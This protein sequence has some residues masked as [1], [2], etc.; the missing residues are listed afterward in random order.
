MRKIAL[1]DATEREALFCNTAA[2]IKISEAVIEKILGMLY[3]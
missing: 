1:I 3:T 2:K